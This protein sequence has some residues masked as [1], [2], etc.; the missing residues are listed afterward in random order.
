MIKS[1]PIGKY[2]LLWIF[3]VLFFGSAFTVSAQTITSMSPTTVTGTM[4]VTIQGTNLTSSTVKFGT[5]SATV[6]SNTATQIVVT[7]PTITLSGGATSG[8]VAVTVTK[9]STNYAAGNVTYKMPVATIVNN[10]KVTR[11]HTDYQG[12]W[13]SNN[14]TTVAAQQPDRQ[15]SVMAFEYGGIT[16]STGVSNATLNSKGVSYTAADFRALPVASIAGTTPSSAGASNYFAMASR[17]DGSA[18]TGIPTAPEVAGRKAKDVLIDGVKG[19]GIGTGMTNFAPS[20]TMEFVVTDIVNSRISDAEPDILVSQIA[21]PTS[22]ASDIF[23]FVDTSGNLLGNPVSVQM[24]SIPAIGTYKL[25]LFNITFS[26]SYDTAQ[27]TTNGP[28]AGTRDIRLIGYKLSDF[29]INLSNQGDVANFRIVPSGISDPAFIAYNANSLLIP[30]PRFTVHPASKVACTGQGTSVVF[31]VTVSGVNVTYQWKKNGVNLTDGGNISGATTPSLTVSNIT[32]AD[33]AYYTCEASN[34]AGT[35]LSNAGYLNTIIA[36]QPA[37]NTACLNASGPYVEV[38]ANGLSLTYQWYSNTTNSNSGGTLIPGATGTTYTP[39][40]DAL[41]TKYYYVVIQNNGQGCVTETSTAAKFTVGAA[42]VSGTAYI[43]GTAGTNNNVTTYTVCTGTSATVRAAGYTASGA[44]Y[45]WEYSTDGVAG[46]NSVT[47]GSGATTANYTTPN[48]TSTTYYRMRVKTSSCEVYTNILTV[49]VGIDAGTVSAD[50]IICT[51]STATVSI[52]GSSG[53]IQWQQSANGIDGWANVTG[54]TGANA[55]A[56]TTPSLTVNT[57]Y[58]AVVSAGACGSFNSNV[59]K[60]TVNAASNA[61]TASENQ[62]VCSGDTATVSVSGASGAIQWQQSA[63]GVDGWSDISGANLDSYTTP[64][65][66]STTYYRAVLSSG[67][68]P[69]ATSATITVTVNNATVG[70]ASGGT[71]ICPGETAALTLSSANGSIQWQQ[72][73]DGSTGWANV[74]GGSGATTLNYTTTTLSSTTYFR[75]LIT[76]G[77]CTATSNT[78]TVTV[79]NTFIWNGTVNTN[80]HLAANWSCN[81][82]PTL[83]DNVVIPERL[84]QP[85]VMNNVTALGKTLDIQAGAV[86]VVNAMRNIQI[87]G[88]INIDPSGNM[89][90]SN[91]ANLVQ[92][93][94]GTTNNN[95][96][97][98][99][100]YRKSSLL[101]RQDYTLWSTPVEGQNLFQFSPLTLANRFYTYNTSLDLY[102][103]VPNLSAES[104]TT[105]TTGVGYLIR[106]PNGNP[107]QGYNAGTTPITLTQEFMGVPNNGNIN[108]PV[109]L[110]LNRYNGI[111]NPYPSAINI[112]NFIDEN[113]DELDNLGTLYFWRKKNNNANTSYASITKF[114]YSENFA[115]GGDTGSPYFTDGQQSNWVINPGQG[116]VIRATPGTSHISFTNAMRRTVNNTQFF[117][118]QDEMQASKFRLNL[119]AAT[120][121]FN[122]AVIGYSNMT[123]NGLDYGYDGI[124]LNDGSIAIYTSAE[125][126]NL[127]IQAKGGFTASDV[128]PVSYRVNNAG[129]YTMKLKNPDGLFAGSQEIYLKDNVANIT[130][131]IKAGDYSFTTEAGTFTNRFEVVYMN[132]AMGTGDNTLTANNVVVFKKD[133]VLNISTGAVEMKD[134]R[135]FDTRGR[136]VHEVKGI[137]ASTAT[138]GNIAVQEQMMIVQI[139]TVDGAVVSKKAVY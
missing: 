72:S 76:S 133:G 119:V 131:D 56:Y 126:T 12:Y 59:T 10:A 1:L 95:T 82:I 94:A 89:L 85:V 6:V 104:T 54:G 16:Y 79:N 99:I 97:N 51:G 44:T 15:H 40:V 14:T 93:S 88:A 80:W 39:P 103:A 67:V 29:G 24:S 136:L 98:I 106:M 120:G 19:L 70:T 41:G 18:T 17:M 45:Q 123:T 26:T 27:L 34:A 100:V 77:S 49:Q 60:V 112:H 47:G 101:Y 62:S 68:C 86:L 135:L 4:K 30:S 138:V 115:E 69:S 84:N 108:V 64:A 105:F 46:W 71:T 111:G 124:L 110:A 128:V 122:Q 8:T 28:I 96:G 48:L 109:S 57:Y 92:D 139:T 7:V 137:N 33:V 21:D 66:T 75:A 63:N 20:S 43:G 81:A 36:V 83:N 42:A 116:F 53:N 118:N 13:T 121:E 50:Q 55:S 129:S 125:N 107:V 5:T 32:T 132:A 78:V 73:A 91:T 102:V 11:L 65:L 23:Y 113:S 37:D 90:I 35:V 31:N 3:F 58:R 130:H 38:I 61:G 127:T 52:S 74:S 9:N 25:D 117:R 114:A 2:P 22:S 134:V 87:L